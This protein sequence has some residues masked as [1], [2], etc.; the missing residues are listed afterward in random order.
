MSHRPGLANIQNKQL[1]AQYIEFLTILAHKPA[2]SIGDAL[3]ATYYLI[4][5]D[6]IDEVLCLSCLCII[7]MTI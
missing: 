6:R 1:E 7:C 5:Q 4:L 2:L 3:A